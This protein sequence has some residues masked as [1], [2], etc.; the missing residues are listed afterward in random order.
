MSKRRL[1]IE[2]TREDQI[3]IQNLLPWGVIGR[4]IR[5]L[6]REVLDLVEEHG[7]IVIGALLTGKVS[8]YELLQKG[9]K[10]SEPR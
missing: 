7:E 8:V 10:K 2:I 3:R 9:G 4:V 6:L 1:S 5:L